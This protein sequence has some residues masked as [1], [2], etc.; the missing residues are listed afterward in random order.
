MTNFPVL[1]ENI[2]V[3]PIMSALERNPDLWNAINS[4]SNFPESPHR[5]ASDIWL[6]YNDYQNFIDSPLTFNDPHIPVWYPAWKKLPE[7]KPIIFDLMGVLHGEMIGCVLITKVPAGK[8][9]Y[10]HVDQG[11]HVGYYDKFYVQIQGAEGCHFY[12]EDK[13]KT[14]E[15]APKTGQVYLFDNRK[16]HWVHNDS[17][18][19]RITMIVC[20]RTQL[21]GR[22]KND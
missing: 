1:F 19:D 15:F 20:I 11:W 12:C 9:V 10:K 18:V 5:E 17:A 6:R 8:K 13:G 21:F 7:L 16:L 4:R 22:D 14:E 2:D 3:A